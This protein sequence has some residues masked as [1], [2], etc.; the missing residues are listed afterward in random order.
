RQASS[1]PAAP[2]AQL[3][4]TCANYVRF[5]PLA[6]GDVRP[7]DLT[8]TWLRGNRSDMLRRATDDAS[9][10]GGETSMAQHVMRVDAGDRS[11]VAVPV[12]PLRNFT[13]R[14]LYTRN[15]SILDGK[16][17]G[18][19]RIGIY[20]WAASGAV[21][22]RHLVRW[23]GHDPTRI[24]WVVGGPETPA[25]V[26]MPEPRLAHVAAAPEGRSLTD[27]LSAGEIDAFFAP[28]PP[29]SYHAVDGPIVRVFPDYR[30]LEQQYFAETRC[31]PPQHVVVLR[32]ASWRRQPAVG[33][34]LV[35]T[36]NECEASFEAAQRQYPYNS[37]WL[38]GDV[39]DAARLMGPDYHAHGFE[40]TRHAVDLF[41]QSAFDDGLTKRRVSV[42]DFF[43]EF[44]NA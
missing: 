41:C 21:W 12:F 10:D 39:E 7:T 14:D 1:L 36:F 35:D 4:L 18:G 29:Q 27:L 40:R 33:R 13:A 5:M 19:T 25:A 44:L 20:N 43:Q 11:L 30:T 2:P 23:M 34:K 26:R 22:Y 17:L 24:S 37:P 3:T 28:L 16:T 8:L 31:Y 6:T 42:E 15:G 32:Q 9:V 38:I